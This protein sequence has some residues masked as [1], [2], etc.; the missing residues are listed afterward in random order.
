MRIDILTLFP[1]MFLGPFDASMLR[2]AREAQPE[3]PIEIEVQSLEEVDEALAAGATR[4]LADNFSDEGLLAVTQRTRGRA[5]VEV[6]G[7]VSLERLPAIAASGADFVSVGALTHSAQSV[8][9]SF[10]LKP[11]P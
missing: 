5:Q 4:L 11:I 2:R 6:S 3:V 8:D 1:E 9:I 10:E 7:G